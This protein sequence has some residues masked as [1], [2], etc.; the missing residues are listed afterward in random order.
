MAREELAHLFGDQDTVIT[1]PQNVY[2][3]LE[4]APTQEIV[5]KGAAI[6]RE[7]DK[8]EGFAALGLKLRF[9][10][11]QE[12]IT[13]PTHAF[14]TLRV[15]SSAPLLRIADWYR[16]IKEKLGVSREAEEQV[17]KALAEEQVSKRAVESVRDW[18]N[19]QN[20]SLHQQVFEFRLKN[21]ELEKKN[22]ELEEEIEELKLARKQ[23]SV[24]FFSHEF[25]RIHRLGPHCGWYF[26]HLIFS[27]WQGE[28]E[29]VTWI[30]HCHMA[31]RPQ[32]RY[33]MIGQFALEIWVITADPS[34]EYM[35]FL[36]RGSGN[37]RAYL[38]IYFRGPLN[39]FNSTD[40]LLFGFLV[41]RLRSRLQK[42]NFLT[43]ADPSAF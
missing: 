22:V 36:E 31:K 41:L 5:S 23:H 38:P 6:A 35:E 33:S 19:A 26:S 43:T 21:R 16:Q 2:D 4:D 24:V 11:G 12:A 39:I 1:L 32:G 37:P 9:Q 42:M 27:G 28:L 3:I 17:I 8:F 30:R 34:D 7:A 15:I 29:M 13:V 14:V 25:L 20:E 40:M 10:D 18:M